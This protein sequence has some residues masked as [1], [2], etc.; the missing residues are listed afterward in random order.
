MIET[1]LRQLGS[2]RPK[3]CSV[4]HRAVLK[5]A[6]PCSVAHRT[7]NWGKHLF[8]YEE[9]NTHSFEKVFI[10]LCAL[11]NSMLK[12]VGYNTLIVKQE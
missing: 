12:K 7:L 9:L 10:I 4:C 2:C 1:T 6:K 3:C 8:S 5:K 11:C